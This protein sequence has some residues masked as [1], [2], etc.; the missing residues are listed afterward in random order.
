MKPLTYRPLRAQTTDGSRRD[1]QPRGGAADRGALGIAVLVSVFSTA[2]PDTG[3]AP[4]PAAFAGAITDAYA[5]G[6]GPTGRVLVLVVLAARCQGAPPGRAADETGVRGE[7]RDDRASTGA[8]DAATAHDRHIVQSGEPR[9]HRA[10]QS[11]VAMRRAE[12]LLNC[13]R[14]RRRGAGWA[15]SGTPGQT[16][17]LR[18]CCSRRSSLLTRADR[19]VPLHNHGEQVRE[20]A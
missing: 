10:R 13:R 11:S 19:G 12:A 14:S 20:V 18:R 17:A 2:A 3:R 7:L 16:S 6:P 5:V 15:L 8:Y 9:L 1:A 4:T